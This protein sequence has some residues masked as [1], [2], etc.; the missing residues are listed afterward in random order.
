MNNSDNNKMFTFEYIVNNYFNKY[1]VY[2]PIIQRNY[3]WDGE[4]AGKLV[5]DLWDAFDN[6]REKYTVGMITKYKEE[7]KE[8]GKTTMKLVD[9]QQRII[10]LYMLL[11]IIDPSKEYF[12]FKFERDDGLEEKKTREYYLKNINNH[13]DYSIVDTD[14][15]KENYYEMD[16][17]LKRAKNYSE[18]RHN[19][20]CEY[21]MKNLY[22]LMHISEMEPFDEFINI[23]KNKT[24]F[25]I[26]DRI[27]TNLLLDSKKENK[28]EVLEL[29]EQLSKS[30]FTDNV[31][32]LVSRGYTGEEIIEG[33]RKRT[34]HYKDEN[35]LKLLCCERHGDSEYDVTSI[36][37]SILKKSYSI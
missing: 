20:F 15:F 1:E 26:S 37:K 16:R 23:N 9:G 29:F 30:M 36:S 21:I 7:E 19:E 6:E 13:K 33:K 14:R 35:R 28:E 3:K 18:E 8:N 17:K 10:T 32:D 12:T 11:K 2:I 31:W 5:T 4:T 34:Y 22:M 27:K 25:V 24:R